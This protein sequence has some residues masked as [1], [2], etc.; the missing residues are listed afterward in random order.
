[1][2]SH[3]FADRCLVSQAGVVSHARLFL[4]LRISR[5]DAKTQRFRIRRFINDSANAV[6]ENC[7]S[8]IDLPAQAHA[9]YNN[10][11]LTCCIHSNPE[12]FTSNP[13][14]LRLGVRF[15]VLSWRDFQSYL[16]VH[17]S[18]PVR[19]VIERPIPHQRWLLWSAY[20]K[21]SRRGPSQRCDSTTGKRDAGHG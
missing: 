9:T 14:P 13:K 12:A 16:G 1:M 2:C 6:P 18:H 17:S 4:G 3:S 8:K 10:M 15:L 21:R 11:I 20:P 5:Q 19:S 7:R